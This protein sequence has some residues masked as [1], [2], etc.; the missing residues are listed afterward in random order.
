[1]N[2]PVTLVHGGTFD[3][4]HAQHVRMASRAADAIGAHC[5][6]VIP[7]AVNPQRTGRPPSASEHRLAMVRLAFAGEPRAV[8]DDREIRRGGPSFTVDT[9]EALAREH[10][11]ERMRL[12]LGGDQALNF[13]TWRSPERIERLAEPVVVPR[14][15]L[16][17]T[18]L[19]AA[20]RRLDGG[21]AWEGRIL[22]VAPEPHAS[23]MLR[24]TLARGERPAADL[25]APEVT[26]YA[27]RHGLY[28]G[29]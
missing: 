26:E 10:P 17:A 13:H 28:R 4:P 20:L 11:A 19:A 25:L 29:G 5:I 14:S 21:S 2:G 16:D 24:Q 6:R 15:P 27:L 8:I 18:A 9:L 22:P 1:M 3:P 7:A 12:L 23:T